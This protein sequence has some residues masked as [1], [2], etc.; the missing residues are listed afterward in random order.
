MLS[1]NKWE[2]CGLTGSSSVELD[3]LVLISG[4]QYH[5]ELRAINFA[6]LASNS[7]G[8]NVTVVTDPPQVTGNLYCN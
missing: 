2:K 7:I 1:E 4:G 6:N 5:L 8:A 3:G